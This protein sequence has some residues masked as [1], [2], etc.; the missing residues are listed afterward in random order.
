MIR[1]PFSRLKWAFSGIIAVAIAAMLILAPSFLKQ[2]IEPD[3]ITRFQSHVSLRSIPPKAEEEEPPPPEEEQK[4][5]PPMEEPVAVMELSAPPVSPIQPELL[6]IDIATNL[7]QAV[8]VRI[9]KQTGALSL[10]N[11]DEAP[12]PV[13]TPPPMYPEKARRRRVETKLTVKM[14]INADG[15]VAK[16]NIVNGE[17]LEIFSSAALRAVKK[18]RFK[19]ARLKGKAVAVIV[20]LPLEFTCTN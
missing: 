12:V 15:T 16:A 5:E 14:V 4:P 20:S 3:T 18:W 2:D 6:D 7:S 8:P 19:P 10:R 13:Y 11:V 17:H 1:T 9:P